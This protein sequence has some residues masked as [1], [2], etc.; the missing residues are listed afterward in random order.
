MDYVVWLEEEPNFL[1]NYVDTKNCNYIT[2]CVD[3]RLAKII[4]M[5]IVFTEKALY[6]AS[7]YYIN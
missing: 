3:P 7:F 4:R 1:L 5:T 6:V 2:H